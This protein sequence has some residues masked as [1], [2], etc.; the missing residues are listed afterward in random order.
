[1]KVRKTF[2]TLR[3]DELIP[4][5]NNPRINDAAAKEVAESIR[6]TGNID[7]IEIDEDNVILSGHTRLKALTELGYTET[8]CIRVT[9]LT[10]AQKRK[11]RLLTNKTGESALWD[12]N[13]LAIELDGLDFDGFDFDFDL[14]EEDDGG[15]FGDA[16]ERTYNM[17]NL[18]DYDASRV[19]GK[20]EIPELAVC[21]Y[22]PEKLIGFN[23]VKTAKEFDCGVHF[24]LD[25]YQ[26]ERIWNMPNEVIP[27]LER[28]E[29]VLTP[30]FSLYRDMPLAMQIWNTYRARLVGQRMQDYGLKVIPTVSWSD[31]RSFDFCFDGIPRGGC[32]AVSTVGVMRDAEAQSLFDRGLREA[33]SRIKPKVILCYGKKPEFDFGKIRVKFYGAREFASG[34]GG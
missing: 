13:K 33:I 34:N 29:C 8:E 15:Y 5:A 11:Y 25:D 9:G 14:P 32:V 22:V 2:V 20:Y 19:A 7:P 12:L 17:V 27:R 30:D 24:F 26:F 16:R 31:E 10:E 4:Y 3:L 18:N 23:Y 6:Q 21:N 28:F 1:M